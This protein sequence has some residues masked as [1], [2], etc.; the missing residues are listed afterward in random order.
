MKVFIEEQKNTQ[1]LIIIGMS[2]AFVAVVFSIM[3]DWENI[4]NGSIGEKLEAFIGFFILVLVSFLLISLKLKTRIDEKGI[5][6][7]Y[8]PFHFSYKIIKWNEISK[9]YL[10]KY[11]AIAE[12]GGWG[13]KL[14]FGQKRGK[15]YTTNGNI[16][17]QLKLTNGK[18]ILIGTQ[19]KEEIQRTIDTYKNKIA[20]HEN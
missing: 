19:K 7:Q 5:Q 10:R 20:T 15:S 2:I 3:K 11:D 13:L 8:Y 6:Y 18:K 16:G 9:C 12:Y 14:S 17:L 4:L 1:K